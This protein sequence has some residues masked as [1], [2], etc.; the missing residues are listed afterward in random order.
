MSAKLERDSVAQDDGDVNVQVHFGNR[1]DLWAQ[2]IARSVIELVGTTEVLLALSSKSP[3]NE[4]D[5]RVLLEELKET[6]LL[7]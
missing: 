6:I 1:D 2:V 7:Q 4:H 5:T 3:Q